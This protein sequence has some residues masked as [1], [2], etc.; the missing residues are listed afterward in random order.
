MGRA[1]F[2]EIDNGDR[3]VTLGG[4]EIEIKI[5]VG[6]SQKNSYLF[7]YITVTKNDLQDIIKFIGTN[8]NHG[9]SD[10]RSTYQNLKFENNKGRTGKLLRGRK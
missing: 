8:T 1:I 6:S 3:K 9:E 5:Y 10:I 7:Q 4:D 2:A